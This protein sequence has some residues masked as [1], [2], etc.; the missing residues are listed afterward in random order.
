MFQIFRASIFYFQKS[1]VFLLHP[2]FAFCLSILE[3]K[4]CCSTIN[5]IVFFSTPFFLFFPVMSF[6][7]N[8]FSSRFSDSSFFASSLVS[9]HCFH[10][11]AAA[12]CS[13]DKDVSSDPVSQNRDAEAA[14]KSSLGGWNIW[15]SFFYLLKQMQIRFLER[16][17]SS[18]VFTYNF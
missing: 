10:F 15:K 5:I 14:S 4:Q 3:V 11:S 17:T 7:L 18:S 8:S 6:F 1:V 16:N 12:V 13:S 2:A 9:H